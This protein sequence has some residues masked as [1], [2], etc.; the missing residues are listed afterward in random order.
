MNKD[1]F[2]QSVFLELLRA[3]LAGIGV[4]HSGDTLGEVTVQ[5]RRDA[6]EISDCY[7]T[8]DIKG[9]PQPPEDSDDFI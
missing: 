6:R 3:Y 7:C 5:L 1:D 2:E 9:I 8:M 4:T